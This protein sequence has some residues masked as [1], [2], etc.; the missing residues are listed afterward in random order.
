MP[1][2]TVRRRS[3]E[4]KIKRGSRGNSANA[5]IFMGEECHFVVRLLDSSE[6]AA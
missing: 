2:E 6:I 3:R 4:E 1:V 5:S